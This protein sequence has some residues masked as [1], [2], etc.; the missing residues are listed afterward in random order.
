M[1]VNKCCNPGDRNVKKKQAGKIFKYEDLIIEIQHMQKVKLEVIPVIISATATILTLR[2]YLNNITGK[3][4]IKETVKN[5]HIR[6]CTHPRKV[7]T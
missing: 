7:L 3:K 5:G 6:D 2:Q 1:H 4:E